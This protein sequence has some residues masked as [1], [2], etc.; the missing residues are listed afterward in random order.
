MS[1][2]PPAQV[3]T[4]NALLS[5]HVVWLSAQDEWSPAMRTA[6]VFHDP[7]EAEAALARAQARTAEVVGC[8]LAEVRPT[9]AGPE[10]LHFREAFRRDGPSPHARG[11]NAA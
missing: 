9:P 5:G 1:R 7:A 11:R 3:I 2:K 6:R 10:P 4:A 8:Y